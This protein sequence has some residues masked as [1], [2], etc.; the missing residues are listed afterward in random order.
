MAIN[1]ASKLIGLQNRKSVTEN[2]F[3]EDRIWITMALSVKCINSLPSLAK[4][5]Q[6]CGNRFI[7]S[8]FIFTF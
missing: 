5:V 1:G 7:V 6:L 8:E 2:R 4:D 3:D